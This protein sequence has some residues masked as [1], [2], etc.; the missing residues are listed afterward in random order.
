MYEAEVVSG[1]KMLMVPYVLGDR[2]SQE[3]GQ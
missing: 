1:D 2:E 3:A